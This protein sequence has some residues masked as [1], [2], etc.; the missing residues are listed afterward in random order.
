MLT[1]VW[2]DFRAAYAKGQPK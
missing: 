1:T 2:T